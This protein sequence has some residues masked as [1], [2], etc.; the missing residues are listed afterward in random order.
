MDI[1]LLIIIFAHIAVSWGIH[2]F[3]IRQ[4]GSRIWDSWNPME[5]VEGKELVILS[6]LRKKNSLFRIWKNDK[7]NDK[8]WT[9]TS[10]STS[11]N[12]EDMWGLDSF[13]P[14][15]LA[16]T[17]LLEDGEHQLRGLA[18]QGLCGLQRQLLPTEARFSVVGDRCV[19]GTLWWDE[20]WTLA[21]S[22]SFHGK[23]GSHDI[24][25]GFWDPPILR[26][27]PFLG[28]WWRTI[29]NVGSTESTQ[30]LHCYPRLL[31][32]RNSVGL[33]CPL[34]THTWLLA[35]WQICLPLYIYIHIVVFGATC[36]VLSIANRCSK[37]PLCLN[38]VPRDQ[39]KSK[40]GAGLHN[41][42]SK[43]CLS[44]VLL[45]HP[46]FLNHI[47][48]LFFVSLW[49]TSNDSSAHDSFRLKEC[50]EPHGKPYILSISGLSLKA[51]WISVLAKWVK[52]VKWVGAVDTVVAWTM[53]NPV[54][55][56]GEPSLVWDF[57]E[58]KATDTFW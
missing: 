7:K 24:F 23:A 14:H 34:L 11:F 33:E 17:H 29:I 57:D 42:L 56:W 30:I 58:R 25:D 27:S 2:H 19:W 1:P 16:S 18:K 39:P 47:S 43:I 35:I 37:L 50:S 52:W 46:W 8:E 40:P 48:L 31:L 28:G 13:E 21:I 12:A 20:G 10:I 53:A 3:W 32:V 54:N 51:I 6:V 22:G 15:Q 55:V 26:Q 4:C 41:F 38:F 9:M 45:H 49:D 5:S 36:H 44:F